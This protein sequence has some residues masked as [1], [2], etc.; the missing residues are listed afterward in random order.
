MATRRLLQSTADSAAVVQVQMTGASENKTAQI[1]IELGSVVANNA[2]S[3]RYLCLDSQ[4][5]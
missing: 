5:G 3:V 1:A 4:E 2:L